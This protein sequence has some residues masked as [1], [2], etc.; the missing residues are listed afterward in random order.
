MLIVSGSP[1]I[2]PSSHPATYHTYLLCACV[3]VYRLD[4]CRVAVSVPFIGQ[5][6]SDLPA[7]IIL[8]CFSTHLISVVYSAHHCTSLFITAHHCTLQRV[9]VCNI[10]TFVICTYLILLHI[11]KEGWLVCSNLYFVRFLFCCTQLKRAM[12]DG[13]CAWR[14]FH[15][16]PNLGVTRVMIFIASDDDFDCED[17]HHCIT[18]YRDQPRGDS[19]GDIY[20]SWW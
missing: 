16:T 13:L 8:Q 17:V 2:H 14:N 11:T 1:P 15:V 18:Q 5:K 10:L 19:G 3:T 20:H 4:R 7:G 12:R 6:V 9:V